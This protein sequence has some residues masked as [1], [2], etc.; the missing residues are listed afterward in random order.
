VNL[1]I[2][3]KYGIKMYVFN[4]VAKITFNS[5]TSTLLDGIK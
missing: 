5:V 3:T 1:G 2:I 4:H